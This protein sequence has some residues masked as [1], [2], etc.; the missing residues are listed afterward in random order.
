MIWFYSNPIENNKKNVSVHKDLYTHI[1]ENN[2][3]YDASL[4]LWHSG[5]GGGGGGWRNYKQA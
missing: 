2:F 4:F 1:Y 5:G 3:F